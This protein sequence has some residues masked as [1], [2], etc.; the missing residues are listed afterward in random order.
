M[1]TLKDLNRGETFPFAGFE[2]IV[3]EHTS[4]GT[5]VVAT[6]IIENRAF[7]EDGS[8]D[9]RESSSRS[10][11]NSE[12]LEGLVEA[13]GSDAY[14]LAHT[15][16]LTAADG[17]FRETSTDF[18]SLLT[19]DEYRRNRDVLE[20]IGLWW[21][22][23]T[24]DSAS[25]S[26]YVRGVFTDGSLYYYGAFSGDGGLRPALLLDSGLVISDDGDE[27]QVTAEEAAEAARQI[28][29]TWLT[30]GFTVDDVV[31][32]LAAFSRIL[33]EDKHE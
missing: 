20:P 12:F 17:T 28:A 22:L 32:A 18:V 11:L 27:E 31:Q 24:R 30:A 3:L 4:A 8:A 26:Y 7:D 23:I 29:E 19:L 21:W 1:K 15:S 14:I 9:W 5:R 10:Y 6:T 25:D 2:W 33:K 16:D 13:A